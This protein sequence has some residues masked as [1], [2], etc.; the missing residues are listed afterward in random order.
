MGRMAVSCQCPSQCWSEEKM[1]TG[2]RMDDGS[3][4]EGF[5]RGR[6]PKIE[7]VCVWV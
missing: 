2:W 5:E 3:M 6:A 1:D 4:L 7:R